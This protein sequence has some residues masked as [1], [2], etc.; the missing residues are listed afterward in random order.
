MN[1][2]N[3]LIFGI[4]LLGSIVLMNSYTAP[5]YSSVNMTLCT[6][7]TAPTYNAINFTLGDSDACAAADT[8]TYSSGNWTINCADT[9][10]LTTN[11]NIGS[12]WFIGYGTGNIYIKANI[13]K[14][15]G[16]V[17]HDGCNITIFNGLGG[18]R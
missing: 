12:N 6:G 3:Y 11:T 1:K 16:L 10:N 17:K 2:N 18:F 14:T 5:S 13:T 9:C 7:Y 4:I 8:C 15:G